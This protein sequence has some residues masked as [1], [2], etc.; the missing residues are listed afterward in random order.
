MRFIPMKRNRGGEQDL[1]HIIHAALR[2]LDRVVLDYSA[3]AGLIFV[4]LANFLLN[5]I[6]SLRRRR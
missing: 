2:G 4:W 1:D 5:L 6:R 3:K